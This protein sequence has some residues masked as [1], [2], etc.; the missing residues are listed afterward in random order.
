M[1]LTEVCIPLFAFHT[2]HDIWIVKNKEHHEYPISACHM[3][4]SVCISLRGQRFPNHVFHIVPITSTTPVTPAHITYLKRDSLTT[5]IRALGI[6]YEIGEKTSEKRKCRRFPM[7]HLP[8]LSLPFL[9][10][11]KVVALSLGCKILDYSAMSS[12]S[13]ASLKFAR[14]VLKILTI[15]RFQNVSALLNARNFICRPGGSVAVPCSFHRLVTR[16]LKSLNLKSS[17]SILV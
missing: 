15:P 2:A 16:F 5:W 6:F 9:Y 4:R 14:W 17:F 12:H 7:L 10:H 8:A 3:Q 13:I 11:S 1:V